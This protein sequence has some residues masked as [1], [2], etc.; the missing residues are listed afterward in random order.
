MADANVTDFGDGIDD[1]LGP[2]AIRNL[3]VIF[4]RAWHHVR[5]LRRC[6]IPASG[7]AILVC[8]HI[9]GLD[10]AIIQSTCRRYIVWMVAREYYDHPRLGWGFRKIQ[11]IPV[12]RNGRDMAS[13]RLALRALRAGRILGVFPEGR[14]EPDDRLLPFE[15][16]VGL[17]AAK[18]RCDIYPAFIDGSQRGLEIAQACILRQRTVLNF[19]P[20]QKIRSMAGT[21]RSND[22]DRD[23]ERLLATME[24]LRRNT[25]GAWRD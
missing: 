4:C 3:N 13:V 20:V 5:V 8:N 25:L 15:R 23:W 24:G 19:A 21:D 14:I 11:A 18:A 22:S 2:R 1:R 16:G 7:S 17:L 10:P 6:P 9:S 12:E